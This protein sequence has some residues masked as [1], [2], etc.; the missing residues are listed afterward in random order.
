MAETIIIINKN[1][2]NIEVKTDGYLLFYLVGDK[3]KTMGDIEL[4]SLAPIIMKLMTERMM[5]K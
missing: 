3:I 1:Q 4:K 5:G 2:E